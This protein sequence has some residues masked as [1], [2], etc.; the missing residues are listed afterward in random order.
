VLTFTIPA[1]VR[2]ISA[3]VRLGLGFS[4]L[5]VNLGTADM[6]NSS[7]TDRWM[8]VCQAW[9]EDTGQQLTG[10]TTTFVGGIPDA[11]TTQRFTVNGLIT[12]A[13]N[14]IRLGF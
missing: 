7:A 13:K 10:V 9:R 2:L 8:P 3:K 12:G 11:L 5:V 14:L 6:G 1:G 4:Y